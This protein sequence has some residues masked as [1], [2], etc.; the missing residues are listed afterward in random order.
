MKILI[1]TLTVISFLSVTK[2]Q[3]LLN[4]QRIKDAITANCP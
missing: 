4:I 3:L 2:L 1:A